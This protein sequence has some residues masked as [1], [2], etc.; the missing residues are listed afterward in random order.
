VNV[1]QLKKKGA[2]IEYSTQNVSFQI[3]EI[4]KKLV[5]VLFI[6]LS[7][8]KRAKVNILYIQCQFVYS[9]QNRNKVRIS[10]GARYGIL[11]EFHAVAHAYCIL[12]C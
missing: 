6:I 3:E 12:S 9:L 7:I 1:V 5:A 11:D 4:T 2:H 8:I 10:T